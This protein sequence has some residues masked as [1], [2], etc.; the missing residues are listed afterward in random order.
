V[1]R[2]AA[3]PPPPTAHI[4]CD[5]GNTACPFYVIRL[6]LITRDEFMSRLFYCL[7]LIQIFSAPAVPKHSTLALFSRRPCFLP[8]EAALLQLKQD[9][10]R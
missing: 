8:I 5:R 3:S 7:L 2:L 9:A 6:D 1:V 10:A 4:P